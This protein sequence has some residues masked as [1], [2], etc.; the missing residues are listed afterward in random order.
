M[1]LLHKVL[2]EVLEQ[3]A[4]VDA[5]LWNAVL[6]HELDADL[7]PQLLW[8]LCTSSRSPSSSRDQS[9]R[10][11]GHILQVINVLNS[12]HEVRQA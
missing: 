1:H 10:P 12:Q 11:N 5:G 3:A 6:V 8:L 9:F 4:T 2:H 7:L